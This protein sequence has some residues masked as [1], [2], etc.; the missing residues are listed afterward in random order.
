[1]WDTAWERR[2]S[3]LPFCFFI[4]T[5]RYKDNVLKPV[6]NNHKEVEQAMVAVA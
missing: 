2:G 1:M 6:K 4:V 3:P 5:Y